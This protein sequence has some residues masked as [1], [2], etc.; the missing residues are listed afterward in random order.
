VFLIINLVIGYLAV[1]HTKHT[2]FTKAHEFQVC[3]KF[4]VSIC[5]SI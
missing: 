3:N 1:A 4:S 5:H 2:N